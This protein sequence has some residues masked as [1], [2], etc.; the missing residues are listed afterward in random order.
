MRRFFAHWRPDLALIAE[1]EILAEHDPRSAP[2]R[3]AAGDG[4]RAD[5]RALLRTLAARARLHRR[6]ARARSI[7]AWRRARPT[8]S[9]SPGSARA[10][11][12]VVGNLKYD[13]A[14]AA[15]RP[16][17]ARRARRP[18]LGAADLDRRLDPRR[19]RAHRRRGASPRRAGLSRRAD[20]DRAAPSRAR[21][22]DRRRTAGARLH[23]RACARA[24]SG[25]SAASTIYICDT[26]GELGLF[27]RLAGVVLAGK[28]FVGEGGQNPIEPAKL[29]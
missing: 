20:A 21:R 17:G 12:D 10:K 15:R 14:A 1:S 11:V 19:R 26:I 5:E 27:Y 9:G 23:L 28:S 29:G 8:P 25:R 18:R 24:A 22:S 7:S 2:R 13:A 3:R 4:Q 16:A 6:A